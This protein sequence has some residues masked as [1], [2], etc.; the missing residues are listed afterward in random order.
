MLN[1]IK[2]A[3][4]M[5]GGFV[6]VAAIAALIGVV[7]ITKIHTIDAADTVLYEK[8]TVPISQ[9]GDMAT[10]FQ[11]Q[12]IN[13][14]DAIFA[15]SAD[16]I[17]DK[18]GRMESLDKDQDRLSVE[19][20]KGIISDQMRRAFEE[21]KS[22]E[23]DFQR[24]IPEIAALAKANRDEEAVKAMKGPSFTASQAVQVALD[25][26]Q[27]MKVTQAK[28]TS[29]N[30]TETA[31]AASTLMITVIAI[32]SILAVAIGWL[33][34]RSIAQPMAQGVNMMQEMSRG[35][36]GK[37][38]QMTRQDE[39][40]VLA[41]AMDEFADDLQGSVVGVM[42]QVAAG[43]LSAQVKPKDSE[44]EIS[45]ALRDTIESLR[46]LLAEMNNMSTEHDK[47][48]IDIKIDT[49]KFAGGY[50][51]MAEGVNNMVFGH[52]AVKKKAMACVAE[53]GKGNMDAPLEKFP[54]KKVFINE[55]IE[56][57]RANIKE[58]V[59]DANVLS[60]AAVEGKL[61]TRAD[62]SK[63]QGDFRKIVQGVNETLDAVIGPLNVAADYVERISKGNIPAKITDNYNGDFN[64]I[65]N[66]LNTCIEA[67]NT[68]VAD[69]MTLAKAGVEGKLATRADA[70]K[71]QGDFQKIVVGVNDTLDAVVNPINE[72]AAVLEKVANRDLTARVLGS[73]QGDLAKIKDSL[74]RAAQNLEESLTQV[75]SAS[76]QVSSASG[77]ISSGS[78]SLAEGASEQASSLEEISSSLEE[79]ASMTRQNTENSNQAK[80]LA[81][82]ARASADKGTGAMERMNAAIEKIKL[83]S[84]ETAKIVKTIDEI[85]FQTNLLALNAAVEAARAGEAGKG[86]AVVA[87]EVRNLAQRSAEAA[88]TT[89]GLIE[90]SVKNAEEGVKVTGE[91]GVILGEI[92]VGARKVDELVAEIAAASKEQS[93]G[94]EQVNGAI[95]QLDKVTQQNAANAEESASA[96]EELNS[97]AAELQGMVG[98]FTLSTSMAGA[99]TKPRAKLG[100]APSAG[101]VQALLRPAKE[102]KAAA[103]GK[104]GHGHAPAAVESPEAVIPLDDGDF[105][106]F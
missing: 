7:G 82:S 41:R 27:E 5:I 62:A 101:H 22:A 75:G 74:N 104:N 2:L 99:I 90:G 28:E 46:G 100:S 12:R 52:I 8:M 85:A 53:F 76:E 31:N 103:K 38:L 6:L 84:D 40:G 91:V 21:Y 87:E 47:G 17:A 98:R 71:H 73:Y 9:L 19:Y 94:V 59:A 45:P 51:T 13:L 24:Y 63:H 66:N 39:V 33:L 20:E 30:N 72:A 49:S 69:A 35:H 95:A 96:A 15:E 77:Q 81:Q 3:P 106:E 61:S 14:R 57:V 1:N 70:S 93:Q 65:K 68:L 43:D 55:T 58:L 44:D 36:L 56:Q 54:G 29:D 11:R 79:V 102:M 88:K 48:D 42:K 105:K 80:T 23:A 34:S 25:K 92:A 78:Q 67:V 83:S 32:G 97:Q 16:E 4:K 60:K 50:K 37:R 64:T 18:L 10:N 89:S 26:M 86:F